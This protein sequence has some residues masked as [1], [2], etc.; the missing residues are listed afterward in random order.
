MPS[1]S[2]KASTME[3]M[4]PRT[5]SDPE[6]Q[7]GDVGTRREGMNDY[8]ELLQVDKEVQDTLQVMRLSQRAY[9]LALKRKKAIEEKLEHASIKARE[10]AIFAPKREAAQHQRLSGQDTIEQREL[11]LQKMIAGA[12]QEGA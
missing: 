10:A 11:Q 3:P 9:R 6:G 8:K 7:V 5:A 4:G 2:S 12:H 1:R